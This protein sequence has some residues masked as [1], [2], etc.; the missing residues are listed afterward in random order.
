MI[1]LHRMVGGIAQ[2]IDARS[3]VLRIERE[4]E[5]AR[6]RLTAIRRAKY[7]GEG[8][9]D[10]E[11]YM[12]GYDSS[13]ETSGYRTNLNGSDI[14][15]SP[16][17]PPQQTLSSFQAESRVR[18]VY[19]VQQSNS[20][21]QSNSPQQ[22]MYQHLQRDQ[23]SVSPVPPPKKQPP[24]TPPR[25]SSTQKPQQQQ[26]RDN[27]SPLM[28][29]QRQRHLL[30]STANSANNSMVE[31][32][33]PSFSESRQRFNNS[34]TFNS[35]VSMSSF[36]SPVH[37]QHG[38]SAGGDAS[39]YSATSSVRSSTEQIHHSQVTTQRSERVSMSS[40]SK[41]YQQLQEK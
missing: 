7:R 35:S 23:R 41:V 40:T 26:Q 11:G 17:P 9:S 30:E 36:Q 19:Q 10:A 13:M 12:S 20:P 38:A 24:A 32:H 16:A 25:L 3:E 28:I 8:D 31:D 39:Y 34:S 37:V 21:H 18:Q 1:R 33:T 14:E 2:E 22:Q 4:L 5:E 27:E 29:L 6:S 15:R